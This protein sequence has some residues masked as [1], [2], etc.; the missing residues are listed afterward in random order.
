MVQVWEQTAH[1]QTNKQSNNLTNANACGLPEHSLDD[2]LGQTLGRTL[3]HHSSDY[4]FELMARQSLRI[5]LLP[6]TEF[7]SGGLSLED[8]RGQ[9][10]ADA[11]Q[12]L[13]LGQSLI[14]KVLRL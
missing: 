5:S 11:V 10:V 9:P 4:R 2:T 14:M 1:K 12:Q 7:Q 13:S 3:S 6:Y 8:V